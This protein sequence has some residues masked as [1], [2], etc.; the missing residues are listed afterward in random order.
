MTL[1]TPAAAQGWHE[2]QLWAVGLTSKPA[3]LAGGLGLGWRDAGRTRISVALAG[4]AAD[5]G[6]PAGR[7]E[8]AW[9]FLLDPGK[10]KGMS[11]YGGG[12]VAVTAIQYAKVRPWLQVLAGIESSPGA[13]SGWFLEGGFGGGLRVA[14]GLRFRTRHTNAPSR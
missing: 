2:T 11:V 13:R 4:G 6:R 9:H 14:T 12:G 8:L 1:A 7:A 5:G 3:V 10:R